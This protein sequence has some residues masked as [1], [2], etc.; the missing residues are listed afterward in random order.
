MNE[1]SK[2]TNTKVHTIQ[3]SQDRQKH[4]TIPEWISATDLPAQQS[5]LI[6]R[7]EEA[8]GQWFLESPEFA[9]WLREPGSTLFCPGIPGAGKTMLAAITIDHLLKTGVSE[10]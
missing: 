3:Q 5:D 8:T 10:T 7:K 6:A 2:D 9:N 1:L 4:H